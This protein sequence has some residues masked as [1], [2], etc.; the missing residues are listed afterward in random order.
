MTR[1]WMCLAL[2]ACGGDQL[3]TPSTPPAWPMANQTIAQPSP[4]DDT[5]VPTG[6]EDPP[7]PE[8]TLEAVAPSEPDM[9]EPATEEA[10]EEVPGNDADRAEPGEVTTSEEAPEA[11]PSTASDEDNEPKE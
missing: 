6:E 2:A 8:A 11:E 3:A 10:A 4:A 7:S 5:D 1:L 9:L